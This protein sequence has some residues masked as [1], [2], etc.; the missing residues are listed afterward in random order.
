MEQNLAESYEAPTL[1]E[2]GSFDET[3]LGCDKTLGGSDGF[4][5]MQQSI[6]CNSA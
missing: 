5:F 4:T 3:T 1:I 2:L 6:S